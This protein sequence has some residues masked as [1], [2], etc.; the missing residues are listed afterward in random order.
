M[1]DFHVVGIDSVHAK[2]MEMK[3]LL[4]GPIG[5]VYYAIGGIATQTLLDTASHTYKRKI[6]VGTYV[7]SLS[8]NFRLMLGIGGHVFSYAWQRLLLPYLFN[9]RHLSSNTTLGRV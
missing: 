7:L 9:H 4:N 8:P 2:D 3:E 1:N 6:W 5:H